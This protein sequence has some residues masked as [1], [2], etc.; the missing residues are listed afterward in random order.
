MTPT[1]RA[2]IACA[3]QRIDGIVIYSSAPTVANLRRVP[4]LAALAR[5]I[6]ATTHTQVIARYLLLGVGDHCDEQ[7]RAE[8][9]RILR[10]QP[11]IADADVYVVRSD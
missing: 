5:A 11:F 1:G 6:H 10:A 3:G 9:E 8:S 7:R 2:V 4:R